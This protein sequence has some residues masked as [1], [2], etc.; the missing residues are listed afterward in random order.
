MN[1]LKVNGDN[2][3]A[4]DDVKGGLV[5]KTD[6]L[7]VYAMMHELHEPLVSARIEKIHQPTQYELTIALRTR[8]GN[9]KLLISIHP[10][11]FRFHLSERNFENPLQPKA[12]CL[13]LRKHLSGGMITNVQQIGHDRIIALDVE[14]YNAIGDLVRYKLYVELM[15]KYSNVV[16]VDEADKIIDAFKKVDE[17]KSADRHILPK[18]TYYLPAVPKKNEEQPFYIQPFL[19]KWLELNDETEDVLVEAAKQPTG[20]YYRLMNGKSVYAFLAIDNALEIKEKLTFPTLSEAIDLYYYEQTIAQQLKEKTRHL[21][22]IVEQTYKRDQKKQKKLAAEYADAVDY[23]RYQLIGNLLLAQQHVLPTHA[24]HVTLTNYYD[25]AQA[26]FEVQLDPQKTINGNAQA[27]FKKYTKAKTAIDKLQEQLAK[28]EKE[29][30]YFETI[31]QSLQYADLQQ[32]GEIAQ[33]LQEQGYIK[34]KQKVKTKSKKPQ[35]SQYEYNGVVYLVG[36]NNLQNDY[37]T[38]K[39]KRKDYTWLHVKGAP[40]SHVLITSKAPLAEEVVYVGALLAA[41]FSK[42][43]ESENVPVDYTLVQHVHKPNGAKPGFVTYKEQKTLY[44]TPS[45]TE[46]Q[47]YFDNI[48]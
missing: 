22:H 10:E 21:L 44:V 18:L 1:D 42:M 9:A 2:R 19:Q 38:F 7:T 12:F 27:Y 39:M 15:G 14:S 20:H 40:G 5:M 16:L 29:I 25:E 23:E 36:K 24:P 26:Q 31:H 4:N 33:E 32:A 17:T 41:Y 37:V 47:K 6:N 13:V 46:V 11:T 45:L 43:R 35:Y 34:S 28:N 8:K 3:L 30:A 48:I